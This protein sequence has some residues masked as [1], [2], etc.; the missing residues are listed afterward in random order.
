MPPRTTWSASSNRP[1]AATS[2]SSGS[3]VLH[4]HLLA[5]GLVDEVHLLVG[6]LA[7]GGGTPFFGEPVGGGTPFHPAPDRGLRLLDV[8]RFDGSDNVLLRYAVT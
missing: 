8:R 3:P 5:A 2:S 7:L 1:T 6:A 4:Q